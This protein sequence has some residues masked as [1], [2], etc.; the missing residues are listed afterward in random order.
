MRGYLLSDL[1][2][3]SI[4]DTLNQMKDLVGEDSLDLSIIDEMMEVLE[5]ASPIV[6]GFDR[7]LAD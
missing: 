6:V 2:Y 3:N 5:S 4:R 7:A 1:D